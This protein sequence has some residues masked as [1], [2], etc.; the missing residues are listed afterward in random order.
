MKNI[1]SDPYTGMGILYSYLYCGGMD[2]R[3]IIFIFSFE[4]ITYNDWKK[5]ATKSD[6]K[7]IRMYRHTAD[8]ILF[9]DQLVCKKNL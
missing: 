7:D 5:T 2:N 4:N 8:W 9:K 1:R 3:S 6:R